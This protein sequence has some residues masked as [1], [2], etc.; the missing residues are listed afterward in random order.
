MKTMRRTLSIFLAVIVL[1]IGLH[2]RDDASELN[3]KY[4]GEFTEEPWAHTVKRLGNA[5]SSWVYAVLGVYLASRP[6]TRPL[7]GAAEI[8][9]LIWFASMSYSYHITTAKWNG[10]QD[11]WGVTYLCVSCLSRYLT[12]DDWKGVAFTWMVMGPLM[13]D[14]A[15]HAPNKCIV[16]DNDLGIIGVLVYM[17]LWFSIGKWKQFIAFA[18][19]FTAKV[20]DMALASAGYHTTSAINGTSVFHLLTGLAMYYHYNDTLIPKVTK[21]VVTPAAEDSDTTAYRTYRPATPT[22]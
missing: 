16:V 7:A 13:A 22:E 14:M 6:T 21:P 11:L 9:V 3:T 10:A 5:W 19:A 15:V 8:P 12:E 20:I 4:S 18:L 17:L 1:A 2:F